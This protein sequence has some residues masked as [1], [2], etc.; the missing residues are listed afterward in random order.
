MKAVLVLA[1]LGSFALMLQSA[2]ALWLPARWLPDLGLLCVVALAVSV[3]SPVLGTFLAVALGYVTDLLSGA[4]LGQH[5]LLYLGAYGIARV[6]SSSV[7]LRGPFSLALF[8][9]VLA[10]AHTVVLHAISAFF[11]RGWAVLAT[12]LE[13]VAVH[14]LVTA[15]AAPL[16]VGIV[17]RA[18]ARLGDDDSGRPVH[19]E[20]RAL[21]L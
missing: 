9:L 19:L 10:F 6:L 12:S 8:V 18:A 7:N 16:V 14:A 17:S 1:V 20:P 5:A 21:S 11:A 2:A 13:D 4:L 15:L 3:R